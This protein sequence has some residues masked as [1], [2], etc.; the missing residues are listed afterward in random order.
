MS[1]RTA[2]GAPV[3]EAGTQLLDPAFLRRLEGLTLRA[4]RRHV[5]QLT[6]AERSPRRGAG[7]EFADH[8]A[9]VAGDDLRHLDWPLLGRLGRPFIKTYEQEQDL[10]VHLLLDT[11]R[12]M[13]FGEPGK[14]LAAARL[15]AAL[16]HV[17]LSSHDRV[18]VGLFDGGGLRPHAPARG[19]G[20]LFPLLRFLQKAHPGGD[21]G[22]TRALRLHATAARP[23]LTL[24]LSDF[25]DRD[26]E[27][28]LRPYLHRRHSLVLI[29]LLAPQ[30]LD[31]TLEG[32]LELHDTESGERLEVTLGASELAAYRRRLTAH[33]EALRQFALRYGAECYSFS[34]ALEL[35]AMVEALLAGAFLGR[36]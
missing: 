35:E 17:A 33:R 3:D 12:S 31:P 32:D 7:L 18:G 25:L 20:A 36:Q 21:A 4:P 2:A 34:T 15:A 28:L 8:R 5:G 10:P 16:A 9:Y 19:Q 6:G 26:F 27:S 24:I 11:S 14:W 22:G 1:D 29:Q 13:A 23:G 30:E